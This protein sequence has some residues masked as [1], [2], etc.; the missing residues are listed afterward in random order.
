[1]YNRIYASIRVQSDAITT[2]YNPEIGFLKGFPNKKALFQKLNKKLSY[3][4][5]AQ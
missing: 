5:K 4:I 2:K 3:I 1:M